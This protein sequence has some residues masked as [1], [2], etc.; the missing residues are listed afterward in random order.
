MFPGKRER[1]LCVIEPA[2]FPVIGRVALA[3]ALTPHEGGETP[4]VNVRMTCFAGEIRK[5][6]DEFACRFVTVAGSAHHRGM[7]ARERETCLLVLCDG[8]PARLIGIDGMTRSA[9]V[10]VRSKEDPLMLVCVASSTSLR[11]E[12]KY[13]FERSA[14]SQAVALIASKRR[15]LSFQLV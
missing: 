7:A 13:L 12:K 4:L 10:L 6:K 5:M 9:V 14:G 11:L 15:M 1:R 8:E 2:L 3:A